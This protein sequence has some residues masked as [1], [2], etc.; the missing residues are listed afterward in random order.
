MIVP[1]ALLDTDTMAELLKNHPGASAHAQNYET[2]HGVLTISIITRFE[3][4]RG[5]K[6]KNATVQLQT[7]Q[8]FCDENEILPLENTVVDR[9]ADIYTDLY[10]RGIMI[11]D[12]DIL[13]A[14][15]ALT[16]GLTV[17]TNNQKHFS[18]VPGL[19]I[20]NWLT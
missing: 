20:E 19:Q 4:L 18:R 6:V 13:I 16:H 5:L 12:A 17:V 3:V 1:R 9:A 7:F 14:A 10:R 15:T 2:T 11:D 8:Q